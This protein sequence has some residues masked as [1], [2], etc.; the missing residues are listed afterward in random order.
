MT[1]KERYPL[2]KCALLL[3]SLVWICVL[4]AGCYPDSGLEII[5]ENADKLANTSPRTLSGQTTGTASSVYDVPAGRVVCSDPE[6]VFQMTMAKDAQVPNDS[7][8]AEKVPEK[9]RYFRIDIYGV[10]RTLEKSKC[11]DRDPSDDG[12]HLKV[13]GY[14]TGPN[15]KFTALSCAQAGT[16]ANTEIYYASESEINGRI[17]CVFSDQMKYT[18]DFKNIKLK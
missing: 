13:E 5:S 4:L 17:E 9:S 3:F 15:Y 11:L 2:K 10:M 12:V 1:S 14:Y 8:L 18:Y 7:L 16:L 6:A